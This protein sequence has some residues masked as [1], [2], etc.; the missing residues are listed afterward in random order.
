MDTLIWPLLFDLVLSLSKSLLYTVMTLIFLKTCFHYTSLF[1]TIRIISDH[2][3]SKCICVAFKTFPNLRLQVGVQVV[4]TVPGP[5]SLLFYIVPFT[6]D[7]LSF[8]FMYLT[9]SCARY[10]EIRQSPRHLETQSLV[11]ERNKGLTLYV[12]LSRGYRASTQGWSRRYK[13]L[14]WEQGSFPR[15]SAVEA[16]TKQM[17]RASYKKEDGYYGMGEETRLFREN[18]LYH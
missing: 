18:I 12:C 7:S 8:G 1:T 9:C 4:L 13:V 16:V 14:L 11:G 2:I 15:A 3:K 10:R 6:W 17:R 5:H